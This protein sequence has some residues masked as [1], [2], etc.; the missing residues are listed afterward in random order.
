MER[1]WRQANWKGRKRRE[2]KNRGKNRNRQIEAAGA[3]RVG[4][5]VPFMNIFRNAAGME[6]MKRVKSVRL[7]TFQA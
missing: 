7:H 2:K 5:S 6:K 3:G 4:G 1:E